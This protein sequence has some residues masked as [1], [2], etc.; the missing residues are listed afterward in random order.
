MREETAVLISLLVCVAVLAGYLSLSGKLSTWIGIEMS[1]ESYDCDKCG[2]NGVYSEHIASCERCGNKVRSNCTT[3]RP[4]DHPFIHQL[5]DDGEQL[6]S[7]YCPFCSGDS[8]SDSQRVEFLLEKFEVDPADMDREI[9]AK[10]K[11]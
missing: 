7:K 11:K 3:V 8:V 10:R 2:E 5:V 6:E 1:V 9:I 4:D